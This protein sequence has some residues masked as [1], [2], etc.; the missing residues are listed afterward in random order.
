MFCRIQNLL[1]TSH[2]LKESMKSEFMQSRYYIWSRG[3]RRPRIPNF[4]EIR[5]GFRDKI[6][7]RSSPL[8]RLL[9]G[10]Y[11]N[12]ERLLLNSYYAPSAKLSDFEQRIC[13]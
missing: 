8:I 12:K 1:S 2:F 5:G 10:L 4:N 11:A 6:Y 13:I 7:K 3:A 9:H